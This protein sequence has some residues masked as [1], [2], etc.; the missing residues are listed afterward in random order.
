L[1]A[2]SARYVRYSA[3]AGSSNTS[4]APGL[5]PDNVLADK[6]VIGLVV[7]RATDPAFFVQAEPPLKPFIL[8]APD[9]PVHE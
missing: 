5:S 1:P 8:A 3:R 9:R 4:K 2:T 7:Q 6:A